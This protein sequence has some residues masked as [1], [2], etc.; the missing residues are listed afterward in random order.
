[1]ISNSYYNLGKDFYQKGSIDQA[2]DPKLI[3][4]NSNLAEE[5]QLNL[6]E[7]NEYL[8]N[9]FT[10]NKLLKNSKPISLAYAGHQF[11][12]F[13]SQLGDGRAVLLGEVKNKSG[14]LFDIQ[15]KGSGKN[16][17][18]RGG[19]GKY[20][21]DAAIK[22][23]ILSESMFYLN[24]PTTRSLALIKSS[25]FIRRE[26]LIPS[27]VMTRIAKS[28]IR[29][30]SFE[31]FSY[32]DDFKN[33]KLLADYT[34]KRHFLELQF[35]ENSYLSLLREVMILQI[36]L[37]ASWMSIGFVHGVMNT[38]NISISGQTIDYGPAAFIDQYQSNKSFS[39]IDRNSR[40]SFSNQKNI[41]LWNMV[42]FAE[43]IL[44]LINPDVN[45]AIE[46]V[47]LELNQFSNLFDKIYFIKMLSK[48][49]IFDF[50]GDQEDKKLITEFLS[51]LEENNLDFTNSFR[52]LSD[53]LINKTIFPSQCYKYKIWQKKWLQRINKQNIAYVKIFN[54]MNEVNPA[55]IP[56]S[57]IIASIVKK[58]LINNDYDEFIEFVELSKNPFIRK[59]SIIEKKYNKYYLPPNKQEEIKYSFCGT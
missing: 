45:K 17:F 32:R 26:S 22:E 10:G 33:L 5:L 54:K 12:N 23:Y 42:K 46:L 34:I 1:M 7:D 55:L 37:V 4:F 3:I 24:I 29:I 30:G 59:Q 18:S 39:Y 28:H 58:I 53:I 40:Y 48:I 21:L 41:M 51:L 6:K 9:I 35:Q 15:L 13:V 20:P 2:I 47:E 19:D 43:S 16:Y 14:N 44:N 31:Y 38:D 27:S 50:T 52:I 49:G 11:G 56:R 36:E 8:L 57:H 25:E